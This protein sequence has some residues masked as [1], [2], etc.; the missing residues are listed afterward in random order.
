M[1]GLYLA[2]QNLRGSLDATGGASG[3]DNLCVLST[4]T[5]LNLRNNA[6]SGPLPAVSVAS[7]LPGLL[8]LDVSGNQLSGQIPSWLSANSGFRFLDLGELRLE[9]PSSSDEI[10]SELKPLVDRCLKVDVKCGG[11]PPLSCAAFLSSEG[12]RYK[13]RT[14][15]PGECT[16]CR[17]L[18]A[19]II[20]LGAF[21]V[22][23][24]LAVGAYV[25][26]IARYG[27]D[28]LKRW[29]STVGILLNHYQTIGIIGNLSV[30]WPPAVT[31]ITVTLSGNILDLSFVR[32]EC[33]LLD[34]N[35]SPYYIFTSGALGIVLGVITL[36]TLAK[37]FIV[38]VASH[39]LQRKTASQ[40]ADG[41]EFMQSIIFSAQLT[42]TWNIATQLL[43]TAF[44]GE[45]YGAL[46]GVMACVL[47]LVDLGFVAYYYV[48]IRRIDAERQ[49]KKQ[50]ALGE[51]SDRRSCDAGG[52]PDAAALNSTAL[53]VIVPADLEARSAIP[54]ARKRRCAPKIDVDMNYRMSYLTDRFA[55][56]EPRWQFVVWLRQA[57]LFLDAA[58]ADRLIV[59]DIV[60][61]PSAFNASADLN[62]SAAEALERAA[63]DAVYGS[64][65]TQSDLIAS[66]HGSSLIWLWV[67]V[68]VAL[69]VLGSF[70]WRHVIKRPYEFP[71][72]NLI[73]S[74]LYCANMVIISL[75][76][77]YTLFGSSRI[78][79]S[80]RTWLQ[81]LVEIIMVIVL[82]GSIVGSAL[83]LAWGY[84]G[85]RQ[86]EGLT[87]G[88]V[89]PPRD[90]RQ[91]RAQAPTARART[92]PTSQP[93]LGAALAAGSSAKRR[94]SVRS[95]PAQSPPAS[96]SPFQRARLR[97]QRRSS[98]GGLFSRRVSAPLCTGDGSAEAGGN[99]C[100]RDGEAHMSIVRDDGS[101]VANCAPPPPHSG[102]AR[103][104]N[105]LS[106]KS[107]A[108]GINERRRSQAKAKGKQRSDAPTAALD[109][110]SSDHG[111]ALTDLGAW[112]QTPGSLVLSTF[113]QTNAA[114][115]DCI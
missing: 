44:T 39:F 35:V 57:L 72:Q 46:G 55:D 27:E 111:V 81:P 16:E 90:R 64:N 15:A 24:V 52:G 80:L 54:P 77:I 97:A 1:V 104:A 25:W 5:M 33:L 86:L 29:V 92:H 108:R 103:C 65:A 8:S 84:W 12:N 3:D 96:T 6:L 85:N 82:I 63:I 69:L 113:G 112:R 48:H 70:W 98:L 68:A 30:E 23:C 28:F 49:R 2:D 10:R 115:S 45:L 61:R 9:Y 107:V 20:L 95:S 106:T 34:A 58:I 93:G 89:P 71:F 94:G 74:W 18:L 7:C 101:L 42:P 83:Y 66:L 38:Y 73:E 62:V 91:S 51:A 17:G 75:G 105:Q 19:P 26:L 60:E 22:G 100:C 87:R 102:L 50:A 59:Q 36:L 56:A 76:G 11:L 79:E 41:V 109:A 78:S 99:R 114:L 13:P 37:L 47:L 14:D 40:A 53:V 67:H 31:W 32:P 88:F 21:F 43:F 4:L 110:P